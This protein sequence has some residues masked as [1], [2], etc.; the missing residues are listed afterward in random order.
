M[1]G[2]DL[3]LEPGVSSHRDDR[4][5]WMFVTFAVMVWVLSIIILTYIS[6]KV[7]IPWLVHA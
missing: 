6:W 5:G 4:S 1:D 2:L 7:L 3:V